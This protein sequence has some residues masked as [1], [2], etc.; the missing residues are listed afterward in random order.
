MDGRCKAG[1]DVFL[2]TCIAICLAL[3]ACNGAFLSEDGPLRNA[4]FMGADIRFEDAGPGNRLPYALVAVTSAILNTMAQEDAPMGFQ[5]LPKGAPIA[6]VRIGIGDV[7]GVTIFESTPGGLFIPADAGSRPGNFVQL[8]AQQVDQ[9]GNIS[10][11]FGG[12]IRAAGK[13]PI[14]IQAAI[15]NRLAG[16]ALEP[17]AVVSVI[18]Q[19]ANVVAVFGDVMQSTRFPL[20][21]GGERILGAIARAGG[22]KFPAYESYVTI[23][24]GGRADRALLS[25]IGENPAFNAELQPGDT[26]Y[27]SHEPRYFLSLGATGIAQSIG[28]LNKR[29]PFEDTKLSLADALAKVGGLADDRANPRAVFLYRFEPRAAVE[30]MVGALPPG[31]PSVV[32]V[33]YALD[34]SQADGFFLASRLPMRGEDVLF[35]S[36]APAAELSK[37]LNLLLPL[38]Y[39]AANFRS[40]FQ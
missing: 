9:A 11:P 12:A 36:D 20:D 14:Q 27:V 39:S 4:V 17:Q 26:L 18:E 19:H 24:R 13:T 31:L 8:P 37:V 15:Q 1:H 3:T 40:G 30:A 38:G 28:L 29:V 34:L 32:P 35:V 23:Q 21:G 10:V 22:P 16:R 5:N 7:L 33:V 6:T 25:A 2:C